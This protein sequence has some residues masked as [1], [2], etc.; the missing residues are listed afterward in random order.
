MVLIQVEES[1]NF[2]YL[3]LWHMQ[4]T[5]NT[6]VFLVALLATMG[7]CGRQGMPGQWGARGHFLNNILIKKSCIV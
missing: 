7:S 3:V 4:S 6:P 2:A 5:P 1:N